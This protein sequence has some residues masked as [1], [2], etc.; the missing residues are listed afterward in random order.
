MVEWECLLA[1]GSFDALVAA[2]EPRIVAGE[3]EGGCVVF[4]ISPV[5]CTALAEAE[6]P[7]LCELAA[8]VSG[9]RRQSHGVYCRG[10]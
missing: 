1:G 10:A 8:L 3:D 9:A 5:L 7:K 4:A 2:G 6:R